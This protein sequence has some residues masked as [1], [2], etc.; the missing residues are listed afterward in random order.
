MLVL[1]RKLNEKIVISDEITITV[2]K[3]ARRIVHIGV[4]AP[5]G[6]SIVTKS[7]T[8]PNPAPGYQSPGSMPEQPTKAEAPKEPPPAELGQPQPPASATQRR[9]R[10]RRRQLER[11][12]PSA[13]EANLPPSCTDRKG[14]LTS[15]N[16]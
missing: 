1:S 3:I 12:R 10:R 9:R 6:V 15:T 7:A 14:K 11:S 16:E 13:A 2:T 8:I 5:E 4:E